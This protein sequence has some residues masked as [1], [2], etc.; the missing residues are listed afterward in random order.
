MAV[1]AMETAKE[2]IQAVS[3][4]LFE[5]PVVNGDYVQR[6]LS[7]STRGALNAIGKLVDAG[8]LAKSG[9]DRRNR[10]WQASAVL[11]ATDAFAARA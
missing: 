7:L 2:Q 1:E 3:D 9:S 6:T 11:E 8:V 4:A 5:Q 10:V